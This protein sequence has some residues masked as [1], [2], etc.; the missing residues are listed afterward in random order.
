MEQA[1]ILEEKKSSKASKKVLIKVAT[2]SIPSYCMST[3]ELL[4]SLL[5]N[6]HKMMNSFWWDHGNDHNKG[7]KW[8]PWEILCR[9]KVKGGMGFRNLHIFNVACWAY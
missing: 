9:P 5:D 8:D 7:I 3:F 2:Q 4:N 1:S 6:L